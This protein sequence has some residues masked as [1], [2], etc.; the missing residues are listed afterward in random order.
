MTSQDALGR[1]L[2]DY[3]VEVVARDRSSI[4]AAIALSRKVEVFVANLPNEGP[5]VLIDAASRLQRSGLSPVPHIVARN[6]ADA[7]ELDGLLARLAGEAGVER[8]LVLGGDRDG[9]AGPFMSALDVIETG[10]LRRHGIGGIALAC[11]PEGHPRIS[12]RLLDEALSAK[13]DAAARQGLAVQLVSQFAFEAAPVIAMA[14]RLRAAGVSAPL[15]IG[16]AGPADRLTLIKYAMR[17]GVGASLR[18]LRERQDLARSVLAGETPEGLLAEIA[19]AG[20]ADPP[21]GIGGVHFF[22]FGAAAKSIRWA[23]ARRAQGSAGIEPN[24]ISHAR[25]ALQP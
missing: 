10:L 11:Y 2:Q 8:A 16:V 3:S 18:A 15:R 4:E 5:G 19:A 25:E 13:L 14:R 23:E 22:T 1:L 24:D 6:L 9:P 12:D 20:A 17:C 21:L 7:A